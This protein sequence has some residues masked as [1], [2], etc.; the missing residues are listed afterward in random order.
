VT[1]KV[2]SPLGLTD[3]LAHSTVPTING[4]NYKSISTT[5]GT[6]ESTASRACMGYGDV[7]L[8]G[9]C[10]RSVST[11][12]VGRLLEES[13]A[14]RGHDMRTKVGE[15]GGW[16]GLAGL[17]QAGRMHVLKR[18]SPAQSSSTSCAHAIAPVT[19][20]SLGGATQASSTC[21]THTQSPTTQRLRSFFD[22]IRTNRHF[23]SSLDCLPLGSSSGRVRPPR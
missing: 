10:W 1:Q 6:N 15:P 18:V 8:Y 21:Q 13:P 2:C 7:Q 19:T 5:D 17:Q 9:C 4:T 11:E 23:S 3:S 20:A 16:R 22:F 14:N 12:R